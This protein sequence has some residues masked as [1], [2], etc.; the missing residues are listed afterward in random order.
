VLVTSRVVL[1][2]RGEQEWR[3]DPLRVPPSGSTLAALAEN[4]AVRLFVDRVRDVQPGFRLDSGN[5]KAVAE[6]CR[7]LDGL[8]LTLELAAAQMRLL[9]P[10]QM[11]NRLSGQLE[12]PSALADLPGRQQTLTGAIQWSY[13]LLPAPAQVMLARLSTSPR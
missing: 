7:R 9:T 8:P 12:R 5:A 13:D 1:R 4:P 6:L 2:V 3:V 11:L 10:E